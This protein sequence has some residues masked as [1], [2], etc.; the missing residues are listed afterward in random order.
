MEF[1]QNLLGD[2]NTFP[3]EKYNRF[4]LNYESKDQIPLYHLNSSVKIENNIAELKYEQFYFNHSEEP[5]EAEY[6]FPVHN[7]AVFGGL[8]IKLKDKVINSRIEIREAAKAKYEDAVASGKTAVISHPSRKDK[9]IIRLNVGGIPAKCQ[10]ILVCTFYQQLEVD[11]LSWSLHIPSKIVPRYVG[12]FFNYIK[13]GHNLE[14][15]E[16]D[17]K[18]KI[19]IEKHLED[20]DEAFRAYYQN[21][22]FTWS[23]NMELVSTSPLER[24]MSPSHDINCDFLDT[25]QKHAKIYLND[26]GEDSVFETDFKLL[27]RNEE[28]NKPM[29]LAQKRGKEY[30]LM[31][32]FLADLTPE[33]EVQQ[34]KSAVES[35]PDMDNSVRYEQNLDSNLTPGEFYFVLDRSYSMTGDPMA[36]AKEALKLFI[37]SIPPGSV[38]NVVSFGSSYELLFDGVTSYDQSTLEYAIDHINFFDA[39]LGGTEIFDPL[40]NIFAD[41]EQRDD[42]DK[43][44]YL[45][46]DG[47]VFNA[48][49][50][51]N[52]IRSN[53]KKFTVHT[54]GIGSGVSTTLITECARAGRGKH[55]FVNDKAEGLQR[56]VIDALCKAFEPSM[57]F[58]SQNRLLNG[59]PFIELPEFD[60][61][62]NKLYHGDYFTYYALI[63][64]VESDYLEGMLD[65]KFTRSDNKEQDHV[66]IDL[67]ENLKIIDGESI[68]KIVAK[69]HIND[70]CRSWQKDHAVK[71][72]VKYQV[73]CEHTSFFAAERVVNKYNQTIFKK[74]ESIF[75]SS[76]MDIQVKTLTGK[77]LE[78][79]VMSSDVI[80]DL[81]AMIQD[82]E[83]IPPD[84]QRLIFGGKQLEDG[85]SLSEYY[86]TDGSVLHL[87]LRLRGGG[88][89]NLRN[90][91]T[92]F[93]TSMEVNFDTATLSNIKMRVARNLL[94]NENKIK[95]FY[96]NKPV[97]KDDGTTLRDA[98]IKEGT[99]LEYSY[100]NYKDFIDIQQSD[101]FWT[102][103]IME[104]VEFT[105]DD[106]KAALTD[107]IKNK[108]ENEEEQLKIMYTWIGIK[109]LN[110]KY[111]SKEDEWKL[112]AKKGA[113]FLAKHGFKY[114]DMKFD[115]L[116]LN[117]KPTNTALDALKEAPATGGDGNA[118]GGNA[119]AANAEGTTT[120]QPADG[121]NQS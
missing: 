81:K 21:Q 119:E 3:T 35:L 15:A 40:H 10:I 84:Q 45:I 78:L 16:A 57:A 29:V 67:V 97:E 47:Q 12:N 20:V 9:D 2:T 86:I 34:R 112:I 111:S 18:Q 118:D 61:V 14:G 70:L 22:D 114:E 76:K 66:N 63:N 11:D 13:T 8:E 87:V 92:G 51:V 38:F 99:V 110:V 53:N 36:T 64:E 104:L 69:Q 56:K 23:L 103:T 37:R 120:E 115:T 102:E 106:V 85:I 39:D 117:A 82:C 49:D 30:A 4:L 17:E 32:S 109:G 44:V 96:E 27:F 93:Q 7:D 68:F 48:D 42:L 41:N 75:K 89:L 31:V 77:T 25:S 28:I 62:P 91:V 6:C 79:S 113:D 46:T 73:P 43:H 71:I 107:P 59:K 95:L 100:P 54:F 55:Y 33:A 19:D 26:V 101:G 72:S 98:G 105:V 83:G 58:D 1:L 90:N 50:V 80:E 88:G 24:I 52:L 65:F 74:V 121:N 60:E 94:L 108:F 116:D 5:I